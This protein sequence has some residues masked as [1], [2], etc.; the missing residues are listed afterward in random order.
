MSQLLLVK[1]FTAMDR[2]LAL[3]NK[4]GASKQTFSRGETPDKVIRKIQKKP[5]EI[6]F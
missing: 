6:V 1:L 5:R 3:K 4:K 2:V